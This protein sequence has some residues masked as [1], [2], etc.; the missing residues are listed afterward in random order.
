MITKPRR[1]KYVVQDTDRNG[2]VRVYLR[3]P[4]RPKVRMEETPGTDAFEAEYRRALN[5]KP[6]AKP[7]PVGTVLPGSIDALVVAYYRTASFKLL[8]ERSQQVRRL[9]LDRFRV[10]HGTK[11]AA[12]LEPRHLIDIR[13]EKA[14]TPQ[15]ANSLLK[16]LRAVYKHGGPKVQIST[17]PAMA[18]PYLPSA[19]PEG[20]HPWTLEEV[21]QFEAKYPVG[22]KPRLA[23]A[24]LLYTGQR[25]SDVVR[26]GKQHLRDGL[27]TFTQAKNAKRKPVRLVIPVVP[28]LQRI[29][30]ATP[31]TGGLTFLATEYGGPYTVDSFGNRFRAWW[32]AAGLP[33]CS[34]H[35]LRKA[36]AARLAE[37]GATT[38]EIMAIG[39][40]KTLKQVELYT[41]TAAQR[42]LAQSAMAKVAAHEKSHSTAATDEWDE[43]A[44]QP[45]DLKGEK[46][47]MVPLDGETSNQLIEILTDWNTYLQQHR[48]DEIP[49]V[50]PCP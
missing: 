33:Q 23:L 49:P 50:P 26:L 20:I 46:R 8:D 21:E 38:H 42:T 29:I 7:L 15:A 27:L 41:R 5:A 6:V 45:T 47:W 34:P 9:I 36:A 25:R 16:A 39:G 10:E 48:R 22:T 44:V 19:N 17:N 28:E 3:V 18:V 12:R 13:D 2:N 11:R 43:N 32:R 31:S 35:G 40:W 14:A 24:L 4:G 37:L 1:W 30:D